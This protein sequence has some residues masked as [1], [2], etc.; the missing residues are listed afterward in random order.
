MVLSAARN[1]ALEPMK[2]R[3]LAFF[4][5]YRSRRFRLG[6]QCDYPDHVTRSDPLRVMF[7][8][9]PMGVLTGQATISSAG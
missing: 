7:L 8:T 9:L 2:D 3:L 4:R 1:R 5:F 6:Q